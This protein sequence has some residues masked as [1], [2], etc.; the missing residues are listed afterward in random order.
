MVGD[1]TKKLVTRMDGAPKSAGP[2]GL[3]DELIR[4]FACE[5][6]TPVADILNASLREGYVPQAWKDATNAPVPKEMPAAIT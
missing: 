4:E 2:D 3:T 6:S 5:L 1:F